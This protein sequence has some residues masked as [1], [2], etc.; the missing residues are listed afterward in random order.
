MAR[1]CV[2]NEVWAESSCFGSFTAEEVIEQM[3]VN[4]GQS[5]RGFRK[6]IF[7]ETL[8]IVGISCGV[9]PAGGSIA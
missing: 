1:Y 7:N 3:L 8:S 6:N 2:I 5:H 4:D 9:H